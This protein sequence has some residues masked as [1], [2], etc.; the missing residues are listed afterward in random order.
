[1]RVYDF[2]FDV[3]ERFGKG[4]LRVVREFGGGGTEFVCSA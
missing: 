2:D 3:F 4:L 1:M